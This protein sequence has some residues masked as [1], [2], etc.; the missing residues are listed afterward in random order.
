VEQGANSDLTIL[1]R[2]QAYQQRTS[3]V[4]PGIESLRWYVRLHQD[5]LRDAGALLTIAGRS[6]VHPEKFDAVVLA[7][8]TEKRAQNPRGRQARPLEHSTPA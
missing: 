5:R 2:L 4:F 7:I 3:N 1:M 8:A 6:W